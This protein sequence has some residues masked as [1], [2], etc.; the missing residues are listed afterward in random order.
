M[1]LG[2]KN[3]GHHNKLGQK[4][5]P[6]PNMMGHK[7]FPAY[8]RHPHHELEPEPQKEPTSD[9]EKHHQRVRNNLHR[10]M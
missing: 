8:K 3:F 10:H 2:H 9:L 1:Y 5:L 7:H 4:L 6:P